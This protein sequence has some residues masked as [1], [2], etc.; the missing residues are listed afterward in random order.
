M[1]DE[2]N[3][4]TVEATTPA[5]IAPPKK[6]RGPKPK[7]VVSEIVSDSP[8]VDVA[9]TAPVRGRRKNG[10][11]AADGA[12]SIATIGK[13]RAKNIAKRAEKTRAPKETAPAAPV[14]DDIAELL[15]LEQE[16][17]RL[18]KT[19]SEKLRAENADLRKRLGLS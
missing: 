13:T 16:N 2:N 19:L 11:K 7:N 1:A 4:E 12:A 3:I 10:A 17:A 6:R 15:Q 14:L 5:E 18:R 8:K 9:T